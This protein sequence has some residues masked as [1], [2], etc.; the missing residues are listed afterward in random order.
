MLAAGTFIFCCVLGLQGSAAQLL[1]RRLFLRISA[2][3]VTLAAAIVVF[4]ILDLGSASAVEIRP[5]GLL[6]GFVLAFR[7]AIR[8]QRGRCPVCLRRLTNPIRFGGPS[9]AFLDWY[10][11]ELIC[12]AGHG[13]MHVPEIPTSCYPEPRWVSL[14][15]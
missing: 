3:K 11:T 9:H 13:M 2:V 14:D 15:A 5:H 12:A 4:G 10:G 7:W 8:D 6:V 1:P